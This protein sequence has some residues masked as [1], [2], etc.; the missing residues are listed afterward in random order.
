MSNKEPFEKNLL[1]K[2]GQNS[3]KILTSG[4]KEIFHLKYKLI[5]HSH[6]RFFIFYN[7]N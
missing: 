2:R 5:G 6:E 7:S 4:K 1:E 3:V